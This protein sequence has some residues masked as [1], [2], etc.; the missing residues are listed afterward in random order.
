MSHRNIVSEQRRRKFS[1]LHQISQ[2][3][4]HD[5]SK[6]LTVCRQLQVLT[7]CWCSLMIFHI[8]VG[9][10]VVRVGSDL[11][12][13][14]PW[15][16]C[17]VVKWCRLGEPSRFS[18]LRIFWW[19]VNKFWFMKT[20]YFCY[21]RFWWPPGLIP[22]CWMRRTDRFQHLHW[23]TVWWSAWSLSCIQSCPR[24]ALV[25]NNIVSDQL[26]WTRTH[27]FRMIFSFPS[28]LFCQ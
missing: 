13:S 2:W 17:C 28:W 20:M 11:L 18:N 6:L 10:P 14:G 19:L 9:V 4:W 23:R 24:S 26:W 12:R 15:W 21:H 25:W 27:P 7:W 22:D 3:Q 16:L 8:F 5:L 1:H